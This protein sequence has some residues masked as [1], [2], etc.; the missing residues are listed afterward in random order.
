MHVLRV[1]R[2]LL[3]VLIVA[4]IVGAGS[5]VLSARPDLEKAKRNV[6]SS[7]SALSSRLDNRYELLKKV[8]DGLGPIPGPVHALVGDTNDALAHWRDARAHSSVAAQ[9]DAANNLEAVA[10]RLVA[11]ASV[12]PRVRKNAAALTAL[13][14]FL[15]DSARADVGTGFNHDVAS[16]EQER[17]GPVRTLIASV[18]GDGSI[19]VLD[20]TAT[21]DSTTTS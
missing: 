2:V 13:S 15:K 5:S 11:T 4:A 9:V 1:V 16:Y 18:L 19:P 12:S 20:T 6:D 7:W 3:A 14:D 21:P 17:R 8:D 10:R